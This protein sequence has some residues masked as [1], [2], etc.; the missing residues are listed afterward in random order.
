[1]RVQFRQYAGHGFFHEVG[2]IDRVYILVVDDTQQVVHLVT[3]RIDDVQPVSREMVG[4]ERS[5][6]YSCHKA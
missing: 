5:Y 2:H 4:I 6:Q 3:V 1:M